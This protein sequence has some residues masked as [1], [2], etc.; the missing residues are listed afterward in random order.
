MVR[1]TDAAAG[2]LPLA[3]VVGYFNR[4]SSARFG[5]A[6]SASLI[7]QAELSGKGFQ[8]AYP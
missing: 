5:G 4:I 2:N 8:W 7:R 1:Q 6:K 3:S